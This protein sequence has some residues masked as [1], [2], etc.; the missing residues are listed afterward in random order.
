MQNRPAPAVKLDQ[1]QSIEVRQ[2]NPAAY[3]PPQHHYLMPQRRI[4]RFK[5]GFRLEGHTQ[6]GD[7]EAQECKHRILT[8]GDYL[9]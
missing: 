6:N 8:L 2:R 7:D 3:L 9:A 4:L 1:K 5:P